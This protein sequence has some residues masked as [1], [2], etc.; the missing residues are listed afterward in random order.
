[1]NYKFDKY[2]IVIILT[3][4]FFLRLKGIDFALPFLY[5]EDESRRVNQAWQIL[6][7]RDPNPRWFGHPASTLIYLQT[8]NQLLIFWIGKLLGFFANFS[9]FQ[10]LYFHNPTIF[11]L[12]GRAW[13]IA[14]DTG[15]IFVTYLV[16]KELKN[17]YVGL[18]AA[19]LIA[20][21]PLQ[22]KYAKIIRS[23]ILVTFFLVLSFLFCLK[24][25]AKNTR[26]NYL[27][28]G[29]FLGLAI[30]T[31]YPALMLTPSIIIAHLISNQS[32]WWQ[33]RHKL[34]LTAYSCLLT[35][36]LASP[37]LFIN[38]GITLS[39]IRHEARDGNLGANSE[40]F[41][42]NLFWYW[43]HP[44]EYSVTIY[45]LVLIVIGL[46][47]CGYFKDKKQIILVSFFVI[48]YVFISYLSLRWD[49]WIIPL[50]PFACLLISST[51]YQLYELF[52][53]I[54]KQ[55]LGLL[56]IVTLIM[57]IF[58]HLMFSTY[59][60]IKEISGKD[61][62][63]ISREWILDNIPLG[64]SILVDEGTP[65]LDINSFKLYE[66]YNRTLTPIKEENS[67][68]IFVGVEI[69]PIGKLDN[70]EAIKEQKIEY[71]ILSWKYLAYLNEAERYPEIIAKYTKMINSAQLIYTLERNPQQNIT[72]GPTIKIYKLDTPIS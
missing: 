35:S 30:V 72:S 44:L 50:L 65:P 67:R 27:L 10:D 17:H 43:H 45:G 34:F 37:F 48:F 54:S 16:G 25:L 11:Y 55:R 24:I 5:D 63:T 6:V 38:M 42:S 51:L 1:M 19:L 22:V 62:R 53:K 15:T 68:H 47:F 12:T 20:V 7:S 18:I 61:T 52:T 57:L 60:E 39:N 3:L 4:G 28:S 66:V 64:S 2:L 49:R 36:F 71:F 40:G 21:T 29:V 58:T 59:K 23:D 9:D 69:N 13:L 32:Q 26:N 33:E 56:V 46:F 41:L 70:I 14:I 8:I 31:K